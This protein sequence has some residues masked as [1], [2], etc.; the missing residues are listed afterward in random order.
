MLCLRSLVELGCFSHSFYLF[1][2]PGLLEFVFSFSDLIH[3]GNFFS[4]KMNS[5]VKI[6]FTWLCYI[7]FVV[8]IA[9]SHVQ[10]CSITAWSDSSIS[11]IFYSL[12]E[13]YW[14]FKE[15]RVPPK[16]KEH[17]S[18]FQ[19]EAIPNNNSLFYMTSERELSHCSLALK[20]TIAHTKFFFFTERSNTVLNKNGVKC[21]NHLDLIVE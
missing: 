5:T 21:L 11:Y 10:P 20:G 15:F 18:N 7:G 2:P 17:C 6:M 3:S 8:G 16:D 13:Y 1:S 12:K 4:M 14:H 19:T 9:G